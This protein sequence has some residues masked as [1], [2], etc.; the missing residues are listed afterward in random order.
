MR[1]L[2]CRYGY[3]G[4]VMGRQYNCLTGDNNLNGIKAFLQQLQLHEMFSSK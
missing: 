2:F 3:D 1:V 4:I